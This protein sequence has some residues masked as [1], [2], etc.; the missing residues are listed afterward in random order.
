MSN[1][2]E[3]DKW[4][5]MQ[6][7]VLNLLKTAPDVFKRYK[8][9]TLQISY[10]TAQEAIK[11]DPMCLRHFLPNAEEESRIAIEVELVCH[12]RKIRPTLPEARVFQFLEAYPFLCQ[13]RTDGL[14]FLRAVPVATVRRFHDVQEK[15]ALLRQ[16]CIARGLPLEIEEHIGSFL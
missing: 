15:R 4:L 3:P 12:L 10:H 8:P 14:D 2:P 9:G 6:A 7:A 1:S 13:M 5:Q 11:H 16:I